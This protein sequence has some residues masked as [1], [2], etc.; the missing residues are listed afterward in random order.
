MKKILVVDD[1]QDIFNLVN[2]S[3][4]SEYDLTW[5]PDIAKAREEFSKDEFDFIILDEMLPDGRGSE[6]CH[7]VKQELKRPDLPIVM[8]T[9]QK[10]LEN[11]LNAFESGADDYITKPFEPLELK[12]RIQARL[13]TSHSGEANIMVKGDLRFDLSTQALSLEMSGVATLVE[14]TPI[15]FKILYLM[16]K[17]EGTVMSREVILTEIWGKSN[18]V[19]DRTVDQ[20]ISKI[21]KKIGPSQYTIKSSHGKGYRFLKER[22]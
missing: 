2:S 9:S 7:Y 6:F 1:D 4:S 21:R 11:K 16:A 8:L 3:L 13:R 17:K 19:V 5:A 14:M 18:F 22:D 15:E 20:H 10:E 12:A